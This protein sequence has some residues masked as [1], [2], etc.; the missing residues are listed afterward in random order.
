MNLRLPSSELAANAVLCQASPDHLMMM[1]K[2]KTMMIMMMM[3]MI[4]M[5]MIN[6]LVLL[7]MML[8]RGRPRRNVRS[9]NNS[10]LVSRI[11]ARGH[12]YHST[13]ECW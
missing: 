3:M 9:V 8:A 12:R 10:K 2:M 5:I 4:M 13:I 1:M 7:M 6:I 11:P